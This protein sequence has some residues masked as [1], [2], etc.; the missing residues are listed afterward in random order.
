M[1]YARCEDRVHEAGYSVLDARPLR[2]YAYIRHNFLQCCGYQES[3]G[4]DTVVFFLQAWL[5]SWLPI[6][7]LVW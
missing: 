4:V 6:L 1:S 5:W 7:F 2:C 3:A